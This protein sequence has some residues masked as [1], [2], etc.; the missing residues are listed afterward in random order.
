[1][2]EPRYDPDNQ[3][4]QPLEDPFHKKIAFSVSTGGRKKKRVRVRGTKPTGQN[5]TKAVMKGRKGGVKR[6]YCFK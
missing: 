2:G 6:P 1:L 3:G 5:K 4:S